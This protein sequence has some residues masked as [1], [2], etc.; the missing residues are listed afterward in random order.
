MASLLRMPEISANMV[1]A[2]LSEWPVAENAAFA[3]GDPIATV[4]TDKAVVDVPAEADGILI[5]TLVEPGKAVAVGAPM[6]VLAAP[7]EVVDDVDALVRSLVQAPPPA[8]EPM[9]ARSREVGQ[10]AEPTGV[11]VPAPESPPPAPAPTEPPPNRT[12]ASPLARRLAR[13]SGLRIAD[14]H[15]TGPGGRIVRDDV[16][17]TLADRTTATPA[18]PDAAPHLAPG[19]EPAPQP[20]GAGPAVPAPAAADARYEDVPHTRMRR[21]IAARLAASAGQTP[22]FTIRGSARVDDLMALR[23]QLTT[24]TDVRISVHDLIVAAAARTHAAVPDMN[25]IWTPDAVRR[26]RDVDVSV[27]V[28]TDHGLVTP[29]LRGAHRMSVSELARTGAD[30]TA[31]A[32]SGR[33][34][35]EELEG[36]T[37]TVSNLGPFGTEEFTA[38]IN[39]PQAAI[40]AVGAARPEAVVDDGRPAVGT[41]LRVTLSVDH[42]PVDGALAARWMAHFLGLLEAPLRILV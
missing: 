14:I 12:F 23:A 7:G 10:A 38:V 20:D 9:P 21:A 32:R 36:G 22:V 17:R 5:R 19:T 15:G 27:A 3:H 4:E 13:D 18:D 6:A 41:V 2:V 31:R 26:F 34:R 40:L 30:L 29:V 37:L 42:R 16:R 24:A 1:E 11:P 8:S 33:L 28:A 39:P 35:Q 25:V